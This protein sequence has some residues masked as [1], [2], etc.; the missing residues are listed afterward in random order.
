MMFLR[1]LARISNVVLIVTIM[2]GTGWVGKTARLEAASGK[3]DSL[4]PLVRAIFGQLSQASSAT[5]T[6]ALPEG[7]HLIK[8]TGCTG[9]CLEPGKFHLRPEIWTD[10][11][12]LMDRFHKAQGRKPAPPVAAINGLFYSAS[13]IVGQILVDGRIPPRFQQMH[14]SKP[15][16]FLAVLKQGEK[17]RWVIGETTLPLKDFEAEGALGLTRFNRPWKAGETLYQMMHGG[18]W[19]IR[20][21]R[22]VHMESYKKQGFRFRKVDQDSRHTVIAM[23]RQDRLYLLVFE[24]GANLEA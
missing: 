9:L 7:M 24:A 18:G 17:Q 4:K 1:E 11:E 10:Y 6:T 3:N 5:E 16:C 8:F 2:I 20:D 14:G 12:G 21:G 19:I 22:D 13:G 15:R 23:D